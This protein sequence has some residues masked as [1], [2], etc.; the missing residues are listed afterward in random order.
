MW[1]NDV[2]PDGST[3][4][5][6][7]FECSHFRKSEGH[8]FSFRCS[9]FHI[10]YW[11]SGIT[12]F[13]DITMDLF[14]YFQCMCFS[15]EF[16]KKEDIFSMKWKL[17]PYN[18]GPQVMVF[19]LTS[20]WPHEVWPQF[21]KTNESYPK[22]KHWQKNQGKILYS[23]E[24]KASISVH[25]LYWSSVRSGCF[26]LYLKRERT[27]RLPQISLF[28]CGNWPFTFAQGLS[29]MH[30]CL[31]LLSIRLE[32]RTTWCSVIMSAATPADPHPPA[33]NAS[34]SRV[35]GHFSQCCAIYLFHAA[36]RWLGPRPPFL[37]VRRK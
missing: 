36:G 14:S 17:T 22:T 10:L 6:V 31:R 7:L 3:R 29:S 26:K 16:W 4:L 35:S 24:S 37:R 19:R 1:R 28:P 15:T 5:S 27:G 13:C 21:S 11:G 34:T 8:F 2:E 12:A 33:P 9:T 18:V 23:K 25:W 30:W 20:S 32:R